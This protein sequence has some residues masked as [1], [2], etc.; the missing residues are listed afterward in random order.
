[1]DEADA[2]ESTKRRKIVRRRYAKK[3]VTSAPQV[4]AA[5][6]KWPTPTTVGVRPA[7]SIGATITSMYA[8]ET[9]LMGAA[10]MK[11]EGAGAIRSGEQATRRNPRP[12]DEAQRRRQPE[13]RL[14]PRRQATL[15]PAMPA[16]PIPTVAG[17]Q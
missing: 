10:W 5:K 8:S 4:V 1:M 13:C 2:R 14:E 7:S 12:L 17:N 11:M 3:S 16:I 9:R 6:K 15:L